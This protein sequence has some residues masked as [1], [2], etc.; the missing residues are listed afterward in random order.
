MRDHCE[1]TPHD[2]RL[3][4]NGGSRSGC[5]QSTSMIPTPYSRS[6]DMLDTQMSCVLQARDGDREKDRGIAWYTLHSRSTG[7]Y[8]PFYPSASRLHPTY[9]HGSQANGAFWRKFTLNI[10]VRQNWNELAPR[11]RAIYDRFEETWIAEMRDVDHQVQS[12]SDEGGEAP[13]QFLGDVQSECRRN[14][15]ASM[16]RLGPRFPQQPSR[17]LDGGDPRRAAG[18][19]WRAG[20]MTSRTESSQDSVMGM[21]TL[22]AELVNMDSESHDAQGVHA[23]MSRLADELVLLGFR[24]RYLDGE[25]YAPTLFAEYEPGGQDVLLMGHIDTVFPAGTARDRPFR[26]D[27]STGR[28]YGPGVLDMKAGLVILLYAVRTLLGQFGSS[29]PRGLRIVLNGDEEPG[30][31]ESRRHLSECLDGVRYAFLLEPS[32]DEELFVVSRK[33]VGVFRLS[34]EG[35]SAH[36]GDGQ[37][38][39]ANAVHALLH[40][41]ER[42]LELAD[43]KRGTTVNVGVVHGGD[44]P[45]IIPAKASSQVD[46][47]VAATEEAERISGA[48]LQIA[49]TPWVRGTEIQIE[50]GFHRPPMEPAE[51]TSDLVRVLRTVGDSLGVPVAFNE[52]PCGGASDGNLIAALGVPCIDGMGAIGGGAHTA[53]EW[54]DMASVFDRSNLLAGVLMHLLK[55]EVRPLDP[56]GK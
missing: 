50:G 38:A 37:E 53:E 14:G 6:M 47:R 54:I 44:G 7:C 8:V 48:I 55:R 49:Q 31:P 20:T 52:C 17:A 39:G 11:I 29:L 42:V 26:I 19:S 9:A 5:L 15:V 33:G 12:L 25:E 16:F 51:G 36:A 40:A 2:T 4:K 3:P 41:L 56:R 23:V 45:S 1:G 24:T 21:T 30:S 32:E 34:V 35:R 27:A 10:L 13:A 28:A 22:L 46:I 43:A 18:V